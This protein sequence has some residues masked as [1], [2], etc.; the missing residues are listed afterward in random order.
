LSYL[1]SAVSGSS[2]RVRVLL[3][4]ATKLNSLG[5]EKFD[6]I[7][8]DPPYRG[9]VPYAELSDFYYVWLKRA[10]SDVIDVGGLLVKQ[11]RFVPEAF[12]SNGAEIEAQW[13]YFADKEVSEDEGRSRFFG[14]GVGSLEHFKQL[15]VKSFRTMVNLLEDKG[16]LTT[17][18]AHT[19]PDAWEALLDAGWRGA[20]LRITAAHAVVTESKHRVTAR[21][22]AGL[23]VSIVAVW[24][25]G[26]SGQVLAGEAYSK[27]LEECTSH[28]SNLLKKGFDGVNLFVSVLGCVLSVFTGYE[29]VIGARTTKELVEK[30]VYP[31]TAEAIA[32]AI[33]GAEL[34]LKLSSTSLFYLLG[35]VLTARRPRQVRRTLDRSTMTILSIGTRNEVVELKRLGLVEQERDKFRLLEPAWGQRDLARAVRSV[36]EKR[37]VNP[38]SPVARTPIDVLHL[39]EYYSVTLPRDEFMRKAEELR[40][41]YPALYEE[42]VNIARL[43]A[44]TLPSN[45]PE[46][47]LA[48]RVVNA[49]APSRTGL[50]RFLGGK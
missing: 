50:D 42:A 31:A 40:A 3:D 7:V 11:P 1:V 16:V 12:F 2:S 44:R 13:K 41:R 38:R 21:G 17:Y 49:L 36:L 27:A 15:L 9:D 34:A 20:G 24:R 37:N 35:K 32:R 45:D 25:K 29:R 18:Y 26:S 28:A 5:N 8:T 6:I 4:D 48:R 19:S 23:D 39:L 46:R 30:Y 22:K 14:E 10:L 33:G 43:L 47:E